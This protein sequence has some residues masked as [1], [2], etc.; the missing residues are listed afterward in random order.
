MV[1]TVGIFFVDLLGV[2]FLYLSLFISFDSKILTG[3]NVSTLK[4]RQNKIGSSPEVKRESRASLKLC[5]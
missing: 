1:E 2:F 4:V 5:I 3:L